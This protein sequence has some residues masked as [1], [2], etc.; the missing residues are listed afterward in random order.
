[1]NPVRWSVR[2]LSMAMLLVGCAGQPTRIL[3][4]CV[5]V[6][7]G[8]HNWEAAYRILEEPLVSMDAATREQARAI[9]EVHPE[10]RL[11]GIRTFSVASLE[12]ARRINARLAP[13]MELRRLARYREGL[14][15]PEQYELAKRNYTL[16]FGTAGSV[17]G[18]SDSALLPIVSLP[19]EYTGRAE[20][21]SV[22]VRT[23]RDDDLMPRDESNRAKGAKLLGAGLLIFPPVAAQFLGHALGEGI[24][25]LFGKQDLRIVDEAAMRCLLDKTAEQIERLRPLSGA[26]PA[27]DQTLELAINRFDITIDHCF[28]VDAYL[29]LGVDGRRLYSERLAIGPTYQSD[30]A[31]TVECVTPEQLAAPMANRTIERATLRYAHAL[32]EMTA[33]RLRP[34]P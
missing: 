17:D 28:L 23:I 16:V 14:A 6:E 21:Q 10:I 13:E 9:V 22:T 3:F 19:S 4:D 29:F 34:P 2:F 5:A 32:A 31:P 26:Q 18:N 12:K 20:S 27:A 30:D 25:G 7:A 8:Q 1:M 33:R 24:I 11:A 15:T